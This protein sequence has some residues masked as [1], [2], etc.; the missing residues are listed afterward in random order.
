[1]SRI[2]EVFLFDVIYDLIDFPSNLL[3]F[4]KVPSL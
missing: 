4:P 2:L 3:F 1:M